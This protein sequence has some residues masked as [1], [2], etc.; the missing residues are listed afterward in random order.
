[1]FSPIGGPRHGIEDHRRVHRLGVAQQVVEIVR[2]RAAAGPFT[3]R[4]QVLELGLAGHP[5]KAFGVGLKIFGDMYAVRQL[6]GGN[7]RG[8]VIHGGDGAFHALQIPAIEIGPRF[9]GR[10]RDAMRSAFRARGN[11]AWRELDT[12]DV[13]RR[14]H[15]HHFADARPALVGQLEKRLGLKR[16]RCFRRK[17]A[18]KRGFVESLIDCRGTT[19]RGSSAAST[20]SAASKSAARLSPGA[21]LS[22]AFTSPATTISR[23]IHGRQSGFS[24]INRAMLVSGPP[25]MSTT[26][27]FSPRMR[28]YKNS[29]A[30]CFT[31]LVVRSKSHVGMVIVAILL[32][33][34]P[35]RLRRRAGRNQ[36]M[37]PAGHRDPAAGH[38]GPHVGIAGNRGNSFEPQLRAGLDEGERQRVAHIAAEIGIKKHRR[39]RIARFL[40]RGDGGAAGKGSDD[41]A[42]SEIFSNHGRA[43]YSL[44]GRTLHG[45]TIIALRV[46]QATTLNRGRRALHTVVHCRFVISPKS[47][48]RFSPGCL[49]C[50]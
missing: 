43:P 50:P 41:Q 38:H 46:K 6:A 47:S 3:S 42:E 8:R 1:M 13:Q 40:G 11:F 22:F 45:R 17:H 29:T 36:R 21:P 34:L 20:A 49:A 44:G 19:T 39:A 25:Q 7:E 12:A 23:L 37:P 32:I 33:E 28:S 35:L 48:V 16:E 31:G 26:S 18:L 27:P 9:H 4:W 10:Y 14:G 30:D 5:P 2:E 24:L 15:S